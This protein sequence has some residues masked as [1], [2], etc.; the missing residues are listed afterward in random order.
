[1]KEKYSLKFTE[2]KNIMRLKIMKNK[3]KGRAYS[4]SCP[5][6]VTQQAQF[7]AISRRWASSYAMRLAF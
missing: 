5:F 6:K 2:I 1:M 3:E 4:M 7:L